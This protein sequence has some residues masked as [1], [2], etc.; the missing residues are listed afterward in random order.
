MK[1]YDT[2]LARNV[3]CF[4]EDTNG[5]ESLI[6]VTKFYTNGDP[7]IEGIMLNQELTLASYGNSAT[8]NLCGA[9][10]TPDLLRKLADEIEE[11]M[12]FLG[13]NT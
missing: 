6:L 9:S 3:F 10:F 2:E 1:N 13:E 12:V 8:F 11:K 4:N 5:G 7:G